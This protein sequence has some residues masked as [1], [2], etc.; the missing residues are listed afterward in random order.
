MIS[1]SQTLS[2]KYVVVSNK[3][4]EVVGSGDDYT[5]LSDEF[6]MRMHV[7]LPSQYATNIA[8]KNNL[9]ETVIPPLVSTKN[10]IW[11]D[12]SVM[13][14]HDKKLLVSNSKV[15]NF[16][17][18]KDLINKYKIS[19]VCCSGQMEQIKDQI[20]QAQTDGVLPL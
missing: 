4:L 2:N 6:D 7:I 11:W 12:F 18:C 17:K 15:D 20:K 5:K 14:D 16:F 1:K 19:I 13:S 3:T 9:K 8:P 10:T